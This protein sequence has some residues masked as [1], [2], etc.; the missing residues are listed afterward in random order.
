MTKTHGSTHSRKGKHL[1][2]SE[3][4]QIAVLRKGNYSYFQV[5]K[6]LE[7]VPKIIDYDTN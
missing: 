1:F 7:L 5:A 6:V 2:Y 3:R 4:C